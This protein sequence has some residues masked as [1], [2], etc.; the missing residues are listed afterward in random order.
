MVRLQ[1]TVGHIKLSVIWPGD[2][3]KPLIAQHKKNVYLPKQTKKP[4]VYI[5][6]ERVLVCSASTPLSSGKQ[7][8][9]ARAC[10]E[11]ESALPTALQQGS[12]FNKIS[13]A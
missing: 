8:S 13:H 7:S 6:R 11:D 4:M 12:Q 5:Y 9:A 1:T 2:F 3:K 10:C